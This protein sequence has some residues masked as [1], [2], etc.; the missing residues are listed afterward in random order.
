MSRRAAPPGYF[1]EDDYDLDREKYTR[2]HRP[3]RSYEEEVDYRGRRSVPPVEEM[4]RMQIRERPPREFVRET[5]FDPPRKTK[6]PVRMR[7]SVEEVALPEPEDE[8]HP[9]RP[10][11]SRRRVRE[12]EEE[13]MIVDEREIRDRRRYRPRE[14]DEEHIVDERDRRGGR[15][16]RLQR[17]LEEDEMV[18]RRGGRVPPFGYDGDSE[19]RPRERRFSDVRDEV[20]VRSSDPRRKPRRREVGFEEDLI[21][22]REERPRRSRRGVEPPS[23][24]SISK[25]DERVMRWKD[26]LSPREIE[27]EE[28]LRVRAMRH[29]SRRSPRES[30]FD[31][32]PPG[33]WPEER[34]EDE[35]I[36]VEEVASR[37][38]SKSE[39]EVTEIEEE[40]DIRR[41]RH[42]RDRRRSANSDEIMAHESRRRPSVPERNLPSEPTMVPS[43]RHHDMD[44]EYDKIR[45]PRAPSPETASSR[46]GF[47]EIQINHK[48]QRHGHRSE[49][50]I[51]YKRYDD[52]ASVSPTS[53]GSAGFRNPWRTDE[54][55]SRK[56][57]SLGREGKS[58]IEEG[59]RGRMRRG[60]PREVEEVEE[61]E[62][63]DITEFRERRSKIRPK[64]DDIK[65]DSI[66]EWSVVHA[67]SKEEAIEMT[68]GLDVVEIAPKDASSAQ[69]SE[70]ESEKDI[71]IDRSR[72]VM[73]EVSKERRDE[74]WTEITKDLVV[75]EAIERLGYEFEETRMFYYI[76]SHLEPDGIDELVEMSDDI[77]R[78]RRRRIREM[79][80][81]RATIPARSVS[82]RGV[83]QKNETAKTLVGSDMTTE[84]AH[85]PSIWWFFN[86]VWDRETVDRWHK[87]FFLD[88][89]NHI[90]I[91]PYIPMEPVANSSNLMCLRNDLCTVYVRG[92]LAF[93]PV[94]VSKSKTKWEIDFHWLV[95]EDHAP[96]S[97]CRL[98]DVPHLTK[99][100]DSS[101]DVVVTLTDEDE[102]RRLVSG[103][104][105]VLETDDPISR[106]L[107]NFD[108]LDMQRR[109]NRI[110]AMCSIMD[111]GGQSSVCAEKEVE[112]AQRT[113]R[114]ICK[115]KMMTSILNS[116][117]QREQLEECLSISSRLA[118]KSRPF[119]NLRFE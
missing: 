33:A 108:I 116:F 31:R 98:T 4:E 25:E 21:D 10:R 13:D 44:K 104:R 64:G 89:D 11:R 51:A 63:E 1:D 84:S 99:S 74:R 2:S 40:I 75:R 14:V 68:G 95:R 56:A 101:D 6:P 82:L 71:E 47:D 88:L 94:W 72:R 12:I 114:V 55:R 105:F 107:P 45:P 36:E 46:A 112:V 38:S 17:E 118:F 32:A 106:P 20:F 79:H 8:Y 78:A 69:E 59:S 58:V 91:D 42:E 52:E 26:R 115:K 103:H 85:S 19:P 24:R 50:N 37:I 92:S 23:M 60:P 34:E 113:E 100:L 117:L 43:T 87:A 77:R 97:R 53:C 22:D 86:F 41:E 80:R 16:P 76:F 29:R 15:K 93:R 65:R 39:K 102:S 3:D 54:R 67:P 90:L 7:R 83:P 110:V 5:F 35:K 27:Q 70:S 109:I 9:P 66:D 119:E 96:F 49:E 48:S 111:H 57:H 28:E 73:P 81:E 18:I 62:E 30:Q 61:N